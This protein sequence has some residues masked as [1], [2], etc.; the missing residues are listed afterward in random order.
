MTMSWQTVEDQYL[1]DN[2]FFAQL[3]GVWPYQ[4]RF[5]KFSIRLV[6]FVL[7][8]IAL[9]TQASRVIVSYSIDALMDEVVYL[10]ITVTVPIKQY[11]YILNEKKLEELLREIVFDHL[12]ERPKKEMEIL[13]TYYRKALIFSFI[14]KASISTSALTF[15]LI[16]AIPP[17]LNII[18]PLNESRGREFVYPAY[19]FV[20]EQR[21]YYPILVNMI[22]SALVLASV[23]I[24]CDVNLIHLIHHGCALLAISGYRFKHALDDVNLYDEKYNDAL[25]HEA[26]AKVCRSI[27]GHKRAVE[28]V[29]KIDACYVHY[30]FV[31]LGIIITAFTSTFIRLSTMEMDTRYFTFCIF[32]FAQLVHLLFL[33]IM[34]QIVENSNNEVSHKIYEAN[35]YT[36]SSRTQLLYVLVLRKCLNPPALSGGGLVPLNLFSFVQVLKASF[37]YFTVFR[38]A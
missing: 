9:A 19:F 5:T 1:R 22:I 30:F 25:M 24:A 34:G 11:N 38:S 4:E 37:S 10:V 12:M 35:W 18:A 28:Y 14:Y 3:V 7:V 20:D 13:D 17:I 21:Y 16:P 36:G 32:T 23:Y 29:E 33:T 27:E 2:K 15:I 31:L 8:I 26:Y 6:I